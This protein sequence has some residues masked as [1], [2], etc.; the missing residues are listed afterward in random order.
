MRIGKIK[1]KARFLHKTF[2]PNMKRTHDRKIIPTYLMIEIP[3]IKTNLHLDMKGRIVNTLALSPSVSNSGT[4][5]LGKT[6]HVYPKNATSPV[7]MT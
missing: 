1:V 4:L 3:L 2:L 6:K 5:I 7:I